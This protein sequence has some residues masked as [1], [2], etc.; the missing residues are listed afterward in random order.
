MAV[1][2][3]QVFSPGAGCG[4]VIGLGTGFTFIMIGLNLIQNRCGS[5]NTFKSTE[6]FNAASRSVKP[7]MITAGIVSSWPHASTLLTFAL[8]DILMAEEEDYGMEQ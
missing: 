7:G 3:L 5:H 8:S 2:D 4:I 1:A 6:E